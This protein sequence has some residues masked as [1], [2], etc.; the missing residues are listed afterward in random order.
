MYIWPAPPQRGP[1]TTWPGAASTARLRAEVPV[2]HTDRLRRRRQSAVALSTLGVLASASFPGVTGPA[3]AAQPSPTSSTETLPPI[4][5]DREVDRIA[6]E[7]DVPRAVVARHVELRSEIADLRTRL[8]TEA[9]FAGLWV[10]MTNGLTVAVAFASP[11]PNG[12]LHEMAGSF[13][14]PDVLVAQ[15]AEWSLR[16]LNV[17]MADLIEERS[18]IGGAFDVYVDE[19]ANEVVVEVVP[20]AD[21][22]LP[23]S[24]PA[25]YA[26]MVRVDE[27]A[28]LAEPENCETR[29]A[30]NPYML[31]GLLATTCTT[32]FTA[33]KDGELGVLTAAHC[34]NTLGHNGVSLGPVVAEVQA[35]AVDA[36]W[37][38]LPSEW[39]DIM[40]IFIGQPDEAMRGVNSV[41][42]ATSD[43][44][45][46]P[47]CSSGASSGYSCGVVNGTNYSPS[48]V[49]SGVNFRTATY[50]H[51][52]GDSGAPV[53][54]MDEADGIHSG[55]RG[56]DGSAIYGH[57]DYAVQQFALDVGV[58]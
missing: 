28:R 45:G 53:F 11:D 3:A 52:G 26:G 37:H 33:T 9:D 51:T 40:A 8:V 36:Q 34:S 20:G 15:G 14:D 22:P 57:I 24:A 19:P 50:N 17:A 47:I 29:A 23:G 38:D 30:C 43:Y 1:S 5:V 42:S 31:S 16:D 44:V 48:Y 56:S 25:A 7:L 55:N 2:I 4:D 10:D 27:V 46:M 18:S 21:V 35:G 54:Y 6:A 12:R 41:A 58:K 49:P 39:E 13:S 32:S